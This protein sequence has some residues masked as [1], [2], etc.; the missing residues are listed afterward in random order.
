MLAGRLLQAQEDERRRIA[1]EMHDDWTQR[2]AVLAIDAA[3]LETQLDPS[4]NAHCKLQEMRGELVRLSEDVHALSRHLHPSILDDLGLVDA[5]RSE[6]ANVTRREGVAVAYRSDD[7]TASLP[8]DVALCVYRVAQEALRN[9]VKHA[10]TKEAPRVACGVKPGT[11]PD[12]PGSGRRLRPGGG[13]LAGR[14]RAVQHGGAGPPGSR[15][16]F[17]RLRAGARHDGHGPR[18]R[19]RERVMKKPRVLLADDH[20]I[21]AEGVRGLLESEFELVGIVSDGRELVEAAIKLQPDV[22]VADI[23][24]PSLNGIDAVAQIRQAQVSCRVVFLTMQRD[25]SYARRAMEAGASG[26]V[27]KHSAHEELVKAIR[28]ALR[29]R[30]Y[31]TPLIA[32]ELLRSYREEG[33]QPPDADQRLTPRQREVLQLSAEGRSAKEVAKT[34]TY[35]NADRGISSSSRHESARRPDYGR[36]GPIRDP[37]RHHLRLTGRPRCAKRNPGTVVLRV[38]FPPGTSQDDLRVPEHSAWFQVPRRCGLESPR[39]GA[40]GRRFDTDGT[41]SL[42]LSPRMG[43]AM[44]I[45]QTKASSVDR[46]VREGGGRP[47]ETGSRTAQ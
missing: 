23:S 20:R 26:Y 31:V 36:A 29:G 39:D 19:G 16:A 8:K 4:S 38:A 10:G 27:L 41:A 33:P 5:L 11:H 21:L 25:V 35:L 22:V 15:G 9:V 18:F 13:A 7:V 1:R 17:R 46:L 42:A 47:V 32:G 44:S 43:S 40:E 6:C 12:R 37:E 30:T 28:E 24:M 14:T 3:K 45:Q 2:L 34:P